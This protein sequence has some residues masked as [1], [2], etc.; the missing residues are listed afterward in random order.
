MSPSVSSARARASAGFDGTVVSGSGQSAPSARRRRARCA[1]ARDGA[2]RIL[3]LGPGILDRLVVE[4]RELLVEEPRHLDRVGEDEA[5]AVGGDEQPR[6]A[7]FAARVDA[8]GA[9]AREP[10]DVVVAGEQ[11]A[12][13]AGRVRRRARRARASRRGRR[14]ARRHRCRPEP[15]L[16]RERLRLALDALAVTAPA[17]DQHAVLEGDGLAGLERVVEVLRLVELLVA[18]RIGREQPVAARVPVRRVADV[19]RMV[20]DRDA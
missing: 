8:V 1:R 15:S 19:R 18:E 10:G 11:D 6:G 14:A 7:G 4:P 16:L 17:E 2:R 3:I 13:H 20:E 9:A 12:L 5:A